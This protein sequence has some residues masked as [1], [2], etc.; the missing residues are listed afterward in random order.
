MHQMQRGGRI[1]HRPAG[2]DVEERGTMAVG[3]RLNMDALARSEMA[4]EK[5]R[6][7]RRKPERPSRLEQASEGWKGQQGQRERLRL[8]PGP[9]ASLVSPQRI[10]L[11][12]V[13]KTQPT[14]EGIQW[15]AHR[16]GDEV[17]SKAV[18]VNAATVGRI[19]Q[20]LKAREWARARG[21]R[22]ST[23]SGL[24]LEKWAERWS[25]NKQLEERGLA[26]SLA[27]GE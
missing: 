3:P 23:P 7:A 27:T 11:L 18:A 10:R 6:I 20:H 21:R 4:R 12:A 16:L 26:R 24:G 13:A 9:E 8:E 5:A 25:R 22:Q 2:N 19:A 14:D 1:H 15:R 17:R